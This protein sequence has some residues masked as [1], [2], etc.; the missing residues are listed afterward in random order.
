MYNVCIWPWVL[1]TDYWLS[2]ATKLS[3]DVTISEE[4]FLNFYGAQES[5][6]R[7]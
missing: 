6:P 7:N 4:V 2:K 5:I 1:M 3:Q